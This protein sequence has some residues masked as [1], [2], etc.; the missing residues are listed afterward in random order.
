MN[1]ERRDNKISLGSHEH[2][3]FKNPERLVSV[4][5]TS[6][7]SQNW[8][9]SVANFIDYRERNTVFD[10]LFA[11]YWVGPGLIQ[12]GELAERCRDCW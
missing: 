4:F 3:S 6:I 11:V 2:Q 10:H 5:R 1:I 7:H 12:Q 9:H 8:P